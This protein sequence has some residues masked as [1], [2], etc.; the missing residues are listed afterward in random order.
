LQPL[1]DKVNTC[2]LEIE[3]NNVLLEEV[4]LD[5]N[6]GTG[7]LFIVFLKFHLSI[8]SV[9]LIND[10]NATTC[11]NAWAGAIENPSSRPLPHTSRE[12]SCRMKG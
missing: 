9:L 1:Q 10:R 12:K 5:R 3:K 8:Q 6:P 7:I 4:I 2:R 11:A